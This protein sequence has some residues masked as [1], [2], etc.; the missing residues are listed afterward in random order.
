MRPRTIK[1]GTRETTGSTDQAGRIFALATG[2]A[3]RRRT[4]SNSIVVT[5]PGTLLKTVRD[6][7]RDTESTDAAKFTMLTKRR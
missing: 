4:R 5:T 6:P 7:G 2:V 1:Q 3:T